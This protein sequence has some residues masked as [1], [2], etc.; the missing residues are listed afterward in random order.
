MKQKQ[1]LRRNEPGLTKKVVVPCYLEILCTVI[2]AQSQNDLHINSTEHIIKS[3]K[4]LTHR[5]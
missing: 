4:E 5:V 1:K 2:S 3:A